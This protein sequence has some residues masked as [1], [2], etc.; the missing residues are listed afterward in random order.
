MSAEAPLFN[1]VAQTKILGVLALPQSPPLLSG[2]RHAYHLAQ[3]VRANCTS[4]SSYPAP[5]LDW[6]VNGKKASA[7]YL[8]FYPTIQHK[9]G[10]QT[11]I[12]G[13]QFTLSKH[14][15]VGQS[16]DIELVCISTME[17]EIS[18]TTMKGKKIVVVR[19]REFT[20]HLAKGS[21]LPAGNYQIKINIIIQVDLRKLHPNF[22]QGISSAP[23]NSCESISTMKN[24]FHQ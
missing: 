4:G 14:H 21:T 1:T 15:M 9:S 12:L 16:L 22:F 20:K 17:E 24:S 7:T 3:Q 19:H 23:C 2:T 11:A 13:L 18:S 6:M 10:L 8:T 5:T